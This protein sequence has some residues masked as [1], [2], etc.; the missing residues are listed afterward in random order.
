MLNND[1]LLRCHLV[2]ILRLEHVGYSVLRLCVTLLQ[3]KV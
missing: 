1:D 2:V 3:C